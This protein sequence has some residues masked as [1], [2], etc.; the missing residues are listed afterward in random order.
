MGEFV[1]GLRLSAAYFAEVVQPLLAREFPG[2]VYSAGL[3]GYGSD[4][5]GFDTPVSM[6]HEWGP[7]MLL[8]LDGESL[9]QSKHK[10]DTVLRHQLPTTFYGHSTHFTDTHPIQWQ[11]SIAHGPVNHKIRIT[12][13]PAF[14]RHTLDWEPVFT[15]QGV[16]IHARDWLTFPQQRL[17]EIT[18]G[19]VFHDGLGTLAPLR[20]SLDYYPPDIWR[21]LLAVQWA[22]LAQEEAFP[23]R[24]QAVGDE[25]GAQIIMARQ[26]QR[27][28]KLAFLLARRYTP[29]S[30]WFGTAFARLPMGPELGPP[31]AE[32]LAAPDW[33]TREQALGTAYRT[34]AR[35]HNALQITA[36]LATA[37]QNYYDR[38]YPVLMAE[39]FAQAIAA[40]IQD[41]EV[42]TWPKGVGGI[43]Q[44]IASVDVLCS[45]K[46]YRRL[47]VLFDAE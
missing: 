32:A 20:A 26:A 3:L 40:E 27:L 45:E 35:H 21:Y 5:L 39:R 41:E 19:Q 2:L 42:R 37:L 47:Q 38:P 4:V 43:D 10:I 11:E 30:K 16:E 18:A 8:F 1:P 44:F 12:T 28:M 6:D 23:G 17:L 36:P 22:A 34:V 7:R 29:Y 14:I 13:L 24:A 31:L 9:T 46:L 15:P 25:L 33:Q